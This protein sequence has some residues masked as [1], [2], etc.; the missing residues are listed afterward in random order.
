MSDGQAIC[1][2]QSRKAIL[3]AL[4]RTKA[5]PTAGE[6]YSMVREELPKVSL[7][8]VYRNLDLLARRGVIRT[9]ASAGEQRRYD[10][11]LD[12]HHHIRCEVCG[13]MDDIEL[14]NTER[15]E[16]LVVDGRGYDVHGYTLC[17]IGVCRECAG[18][19][20]NHEQNGKGQGE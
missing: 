5:H 10:G 8:T 14:G 16:E 13:R 17:F 2:T 7:G 20:T 1:M 18:N 15:L 9:L 3:S 11:M 19:G 6:V 4:G 12:D